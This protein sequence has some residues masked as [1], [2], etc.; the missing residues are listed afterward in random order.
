MVFCCYLVLRCL[1]HLSFQSLGHSDCCVKF[2]TSDVLSMF[3]SAEEGRVMCWD[4]VPFQMGWRVTTKGPPRT[5]ESR[6]QDPAWWLV[7]WGG[8]LLLKKVWDPSV[9]EPMGDNGS[10]LCL[11]VMP[12]YRISIFRKPNGWGYKEL[13]SGSDCLLDIFMSLEAYWFWEGPQPISPSVDGGS[14]C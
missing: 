12:W 5:V 1:S 9:K 8:C 10:E 6:V 14:D 11:L 4:D 3:T 7:F 2:L 13:S